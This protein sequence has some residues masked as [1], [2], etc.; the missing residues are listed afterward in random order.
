MT[1]KPELSAING[2]FIME[3]RTY[4][5]VFAGHWIMGKTENCYR[6]TQITLYISFAETLQN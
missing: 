4:Q 1:P 2:H 6:N 5:Q 3:T